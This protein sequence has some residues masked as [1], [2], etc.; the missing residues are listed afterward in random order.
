[1]KNILCWA[2][3]ILLLIVSCKKENENPVEPSEIGIIEGQITA[4]ETGMI[5]TKVNIFTTPPTSY[6]TSGDDGLYAI[7]NV[8]PGEYTIT[9]AK[10]GMDTL[11]AAISVSAGAN[12]KADFI[13]QRYDSLKGVVYG[14]ITGTVVNSRTD[15]KLS[16]VSVKTV[17]PTSSVTTN[18]AGYF[19]IENILPG[20]Y[21]VS[22]LK[23]GFDSAQITVTVL[24]GKSVFADLKIE[25]VDTSTLSTKGEI[26]GYAV[27]AVTGQ[28]LADVQVSVD[29]PISSV[30]T[31]NLGYYII[32]NVEPGQYTVN[33]VKSGYTKFSVDITTQAGVNTKADLLMSKSTGSVSGTVRRASDGLPIQGVYIKTNPGA[34]TVLTD[35]L[36]KFLFENLAPGS[37]TFTAEKPGYTNSTLSV[38]VQAGITIQADIILNSN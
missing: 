7:T 3:I 23:T 9:A 1:M 14:M 8:L 28:K 38:Q 27:N 6:V 34:G 12:T 35:D 11:T 17:P 31:D 20:E 5:I 26:S 32:E 33:A 10:E 22:A 36:G 19:S 15:L 13:L 25:P 37:I 2:A 29:P 30:L 21:K 16:N 18:S 4:A 24:K